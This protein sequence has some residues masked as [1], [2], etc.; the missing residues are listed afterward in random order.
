MGR[1]FAF[2]DLNDFSRRMGGMI[3]SVRSAANSAR[4]LA[5][6]D[7]LKGNVGA[8]LLMAHALL[9]TAEGML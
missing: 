5:S 9:T 8:N 3:G 1:T 7:F 2:K 6:A 4:R